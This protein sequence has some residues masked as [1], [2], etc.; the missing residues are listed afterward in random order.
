MAQNSNL[1]E[2]S[3]ETLG[4]E[5]FLGPIFWGENAIFVPKKKDSIKNIKLHSV[6]VFRI[7]MEVFC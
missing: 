4:F 2:Y 5:S 1:T 3:N 6:F 7:F